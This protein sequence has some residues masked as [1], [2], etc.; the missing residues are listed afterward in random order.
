MN[1]KSQKLLR[2]SLLVTGILLTCGIAINT[3]AF[4]LAERAEISDLGY[5]IMVGAG[6]G[7]LVLALFTGR[8]QIKRS[9]SRSAA[10]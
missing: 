2:N 5:G 7:V 9:R 8:K 3:T 6:L 4:L 1:S 10:R